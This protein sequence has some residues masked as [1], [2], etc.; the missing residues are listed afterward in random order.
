MAVVRMGDVQREGSGAIVLD[1]GDLTRQ[2][3]QMLAK[4]RRDAAMI[5]EQASQ[6]RARLLAGAREEGFARGLAEG[7]EEGRREGLEAGKAAALA[8]HA[9]SLRV[10]EQ[11]WGTALE[12]FVA[13]RER[14]L[15]DA[16]ADVVRLALA[17]AT[18][19]T[20]RT[21][22]HDPTVIGALLEGA[23][24]L[25]AKPTRLVV[26]VCPADEPLARE[27]IPGLRTAL[28]RVEHIDVIADPSLARGSCVVGTREGG[29]VDASIGVQLDRIARALV[30]EDAA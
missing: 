8:A 23:L 27:A 24:S 3:E 1:L 5:V 29:E 10:L 26:R 9:A 7:R 25:I 2:G 13:D 30:P 6:E 12:A 14:L 28:S 22:A 20:R 4:A 18:R 16:K 19:V 21:Y 17:I 11:S 15:L